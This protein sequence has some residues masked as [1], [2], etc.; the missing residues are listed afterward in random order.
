MDQLSVP[1][2][3][4]QYHKDCQNRI[5]SEIKQNRLLRMIMT[6]YFLAYPEVK[7]FAELLPYMTKPESK[8]IFDTLSKA[9]SPITKEFM[10]EYPEVTVLDHL[11]HFFETVR[12]NYDQR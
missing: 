10:S 2:P 1:K 11:E 7:M 5:F 12:K 6:R 4:D 3:L 9:L 8:Y